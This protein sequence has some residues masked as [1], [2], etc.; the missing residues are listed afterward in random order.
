VVADTDFL[1][2]EAPRDGAVRMLLHL[3][4]EHGAIED[5]AALIRTRPDRRIAG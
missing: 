4:N 1:L 2:R 3:L 5:A